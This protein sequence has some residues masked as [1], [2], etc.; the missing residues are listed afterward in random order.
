MNLAKLRYAPEF[1]VTINDEPI[2]AA[3]RASISSVNYQTG[4]EGADRVELTLVN[5]KLRW[6]DHEL[7]ALGNTLS[8]KIGYAPDALKQVFVG[9]I[10]GQSASFPSSGISMLNLVAQD[11]ME[12]LQRGT[13][14][15]WF[16]ISI[17]SLG[18]L[19]LSD[20]V[21]ASIVSAE[22]GFVPITDFIGATLS[23]LLGGLNVAASINDPDL[24][25]KIVRKQINQTDFELL[26]CIAR[27][28]G[29]EILIDHEGTL[30]GS[31]LNFLSLANRIK[32]EVTLKYGQSLIEFTPRISEVGQFWSVAAFVWV[33]QIKTEFT[34]TVA[35][36]WDQMALTF[37]IRPG[38]VPLG[39]TP[40]NYL[41]E[42]PVT[43]VSAPGKI[44]SELI[45]RLNNRLTGSGSTIGDPRI[46]AGSV[47]RLE[48]IG[49]QFGGLYRVTS[50][51]H[52][53]DSGGYRTNFE[54]RKEIWFGSI[55]L[56]LQGA[57]KA[58]VSTPFGG[59][60]VSPTAFG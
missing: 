4:L 7:L 57:V 39:D 35:W 47:L 9:E 6:L 34:V 56:A 28:N 19:A 49:V 46:R 11:R 36:D 41:I 1:Q 24:A 38:I 2:P 50:A 20:P 12:R 8:L 54:V 3:L 55:P 52:T 16:E 17:P 23:V 22:N 45:P 43:L 14:P 5:E 21:V 44:I 42:D 18:N 31:K 60:Q 15:R 51:T 48:G 33:P 58:Q 27:E 40:A 32:D 37:D 13:K 26:Q 25:Q 30:G 53:I 29:M 59:F 10:L